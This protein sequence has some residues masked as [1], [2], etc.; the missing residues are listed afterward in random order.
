[1]S[2]STTGIPGG[3]DRLRDLAPHRPRAHHRCLEHEH[4]GLLV[5]ARPQASRLSRP[6]PS[7]AHAR[8]AATGSPDASR[9]VSREPRAA[10][11]TCG[12]LDRAAARASQPDVHTG[13]AQSVSDGSA[14][15]TGCRPQGRTTYYFQYGPTTAYGIQTPIRPAGAGAHA[16]MVAASVKGLRPSTIYHFRLVAVNDAGAAT[17]VDRA[18]ETVKVP[19]PPIRK[20][21][22][23]PIRKR[24]RRRSRGRPRRLSRAS[25]PVSPPRSSYGSATLTGAIDPHGS[26]TSYYFQYGPTKAYGAQTAARRRGRGH[27]CRES[28]RARE[29]ACSRSPSTTTA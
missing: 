1:M 24:P 19:L 14:T 13:A 29:R 15:L 17:G 3:G 4:A 12:R 2:L 8:R 26:D 10:P 21:P 16:V 6:Q 23:P 7:E 28:R 9:D 22:P 27:G 20:V 25:T 11:R 5:S 18:F